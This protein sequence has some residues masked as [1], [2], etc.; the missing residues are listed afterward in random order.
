MQHFYA[1]YL[2]YKLFTPILHAP[3]RRFI[4]DKVVYEATIDLW[5]NKES[6]QEDAPLQ[7]LCIFDT[8]TLAVQIVPCGNQ[9]TVIHEIVRTF[10]EECLQSV[11]GDYLYS[12]DEM[13][14]MIWQSFHQSLTPLG[15][16][17]APFEVPRFD[18]ETFKA[19]LP[20]EEKIRLAAQEFCERNPFV[21]HIENSYYPNYLPTEMTR[22]GHAFL[23]NGYQFVPFTQMHSE[24]NEEQYHRS[25][26]ENA[27][28]DDIESEHDIEEEDMDPMEQE[29]Y[30]AEDMDP[31]DEEDDYDY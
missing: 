30:E 16:A 17:T 15:R 27:S 23:L 9:E 2:K 5:N 11:S 19:I 7:I 18:Q 1:E 14:Q 26:S 25:D 6:F 10:G 29:D 4:G 21:N 13:F 12:L 8:N 3:I 22:P 24:S 31:L 20:E 28:D